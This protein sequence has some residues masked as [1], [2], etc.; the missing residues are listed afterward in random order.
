MLG[1]QNDSS[2]ASRRALQKPGELFLVHCA[3]VFALVGLA[4][5]N[6]ASSTLI[7][8]AV[9]AEYAASNTTVTAPM[10]LARPAVETLTAREN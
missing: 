10:Q 3:V 7:S 5:S 2:L 1:P 6:H 9:Q 4:I 8:E